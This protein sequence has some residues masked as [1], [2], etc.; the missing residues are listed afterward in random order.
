[1]SEKFSDSFLHTVAL[2]FV[3]TVFTEETKRR[4]GE[5][6]NQTS[7]QAS[8]LSDVLNGPSAEQ[9]CEL[10]LQVGGVILTFSYSYLL[11]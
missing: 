7:M 9:L 6:T 4:E 3:S 11:F 1:M 10:L 8:S 2:Q 5:E